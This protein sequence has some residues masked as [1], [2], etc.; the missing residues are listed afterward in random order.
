VYG[1]R[2]FNKVENFLVIT[3]IITSLIEDIKKNVQ[4]LANIAT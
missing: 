4:E 3:T 1:H 2:Q